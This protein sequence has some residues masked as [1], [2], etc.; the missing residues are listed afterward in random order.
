MSASLR[1][2]STAI[3]GRR[4]PIPASIDW[5]QRPIWSNVRV[6][7]A[8]RSA[9]NRGGGAS[10]GGTSMDWIR[11]AALGRTMSA[12][13]RAAETPVER[14]EYLVRGPMGCGNCHTPQGPEGPDMAKE[15]A[16]GQLVDRRRDDEGLSRQHHPGRRGSAAGPT[17]SWRGRSARGSGRTAAL[18]GPPMPFAS[19]ADLSRHRPRGDRGV[20]AHA[21]AGRERSAEVGLQHPAAAGLRAAGRACRR[22]PARAD[23]RVRR[24]H[25]RAGRALPGVPHADGA[26]GADVRYR[27]RPGRLRVP[28]ALGRLGR[29]EHH[30][31]RGRA[32]RLHRRPSS[33]R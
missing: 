33:R 1:T 25:G 8:A 20:P 7:Q 12:R 26:A 21:A 9:D 28:R 3:T 31:E 2:G 27:A 6:S 32:G 23:G 29:A 17:P 18:I 4:Q 15:L 5:I 13:R 14:G 24:L 10:R 19:T 30:V 11:R 16:G 22:H